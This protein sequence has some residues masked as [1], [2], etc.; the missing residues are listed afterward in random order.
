[1]AGY[2]IDPAGNPGR[3]RAKV[4]CP[5][6]DLAEDHYPSERAARRAY[7][8]EYKTYSYH[9]GAK[10]QKLLEDIGPRQLPNRAW[11]SLRN[12]IDNDRFS[13]HELELARVVFTEEQEKLERVKATPEGNWDK[14]ELD[15]ARD[16]LPEI[17]KN[18]EAIEEEIRQWRAAL[19]QRVEQEF[20]DDYL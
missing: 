4:K 11:V 8:L 18:I 3:C 14:E 20:S 9:F 17:E 6:G 19:H 2:H 10:A 16:E 13:I 7:E 15:A 12:A 5:W 1:M